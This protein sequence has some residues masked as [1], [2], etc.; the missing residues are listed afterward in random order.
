[1]TLERLE[2]W[3]GGLLCASGAATAPLQALH[4]QLQGLA[5][6]AGI[7]AEAR[8]L[9]AHVTLARGLPPGPSPET[10]LLEPIPWRSRAFYLMESR[11]RPDGGRYTMIGRWQ[12]DSAKDIAAQ[13][14]AA[15]ED[16]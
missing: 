3:R 16:V 13:H 11:S 8:A 1:V 15:G 10:A 6:A 5:R 12:L 9:R 2:R 7:A 4:A 14:R